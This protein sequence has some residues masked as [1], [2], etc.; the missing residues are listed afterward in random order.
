MNALAPDPAGGI[1]VGGALHGLF[2]FHDGHF[3]RILREVF[4]DRI[5]NLMQEPDGALWLVTPTGFIRFADGKTQALDTSSGLP[6]S[7]AVNIQDDEHG[8]MWFYMHC[9]ILRVPDGTLSAWEMKRTPIQGRLLGALEGARPN[10]FNGSPA[11]TSGGELWSANGYDFQAIDRTHLPF[12]SIPPP[13]SIEMVSADGSVF[14]PDH[15]L[16]LPPHTR[17]VQIDYTGLSFLIPEQVRFRYRLCGH[18]S[19]WVE[20]GT[21]RE[22][23][24]NDLRPGRYTFQVTASNNDG[25]WNE[26]GAQLVFIIQPVWYQKTSF[27]LLAALAGAAGLIGAYFLRLR[28]YAASLKVRF[29]ERLEERTR[30]ARDLHDTLLQTIQGSKLV[31]DD[32]RE[33]ID[34]PQSTVRALDR[35]S[36]WLERAIFEGREALEVL[37]RSPVESESLTAGLR[38]AVEDCAFDSHLKARVLTHG[39]DRELHPIARDEIYR[40]GHEAIRNACV[41]SGATELRIELQYTSRSL[42]LEI[43]DNG[44]GMDAALLQTGKAG[45]S[46]LTGMQ[47]RAA[48][49]GGIL[50]I[51]TAL[52]RGTTVSLRVPG[53]AIYL[54][55]PWRPH[56]WIFDVF[57]RITR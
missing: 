36:E 27:Q 15:D 4:D 41:H 46:G 21:R 52:K 49:L 45:H 17:E 18:S 43:H 56:L 26:H 10:L 5:E 2:R 22:A 48:C 24:Y 25:V 12:N 28:R 53:S 31:A 57:R 29:D 42:H 3:D 30:L 39:L 7:G 51:A 1:W 8:S 34:N 16:Q 19:N 55:R 23:F 40:I 9:G 37:R 11:Q 6:C 14:A 50:N 32:A 44:H 20:A 35:L 47:E 13:V 54:N 38:R 33:H